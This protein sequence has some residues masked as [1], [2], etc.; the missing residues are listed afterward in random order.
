[1]TTS[2]PTAEVRRRR[3]LE[4]DIR[5]NA[6]LVSFATQAKPLS[7]GCLLALQATLEAARTILA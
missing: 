6:S 4:R 1:M 3:K 2:N 5:D 7:L